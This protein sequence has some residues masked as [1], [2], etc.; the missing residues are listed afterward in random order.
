[1]TYGPLHS[2]WHRVLAS[3]SSYHEGVAMLT[4]PVS[5]RLI[6]ALLATLTT[7]C[8]SANLQQGRVAPPVGEE[9]QR[10]GATSLYD[11]L[12]RVRPD[13]LRGSGPTSAR[14]E[15]SL[16]S[17]R[18]NGVR[19]GAPDVLRLILVAEVVDVRYRRPVTALTMYGSTC[20]CIG[21][22]IEVTTRRVP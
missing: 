15:I 22:V 18:L 20:D 7:A 6:V 2:E 13:F 16:P 14:G 1:M 4:H 9:L 8:A 5:S 19:V 17:V 10:T 11:A 12:Q 3:F 21:G